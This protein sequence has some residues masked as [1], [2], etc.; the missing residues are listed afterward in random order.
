L[1]RLNDIN[2][3]IGFFRVLSVNIRNSKKFDLTLNY[4][5]I[6]ENTALSISLCLSMLSMPRAPFN[7]FEFRPNRMNF[8]NVDE[9]VQHSGIQ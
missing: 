6:P 4:A 1:Y 2:V 3:A 8:W 9:F 7:A 5:Q